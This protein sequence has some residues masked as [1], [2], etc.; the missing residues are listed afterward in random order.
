MDERIALITI[1]HSAQPL[2]LSH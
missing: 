1:T 2:Q